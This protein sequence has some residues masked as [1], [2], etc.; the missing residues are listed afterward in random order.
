MVLQHYGFIKRKCYYK[1]YGA[2]KRKMQVQ[3]YGAIKRKCWL[4]SPENA[5]TKVEILFLISVNLDVKCLQ[6]YSWFVEIY[7]KSDYLT[8]NMIT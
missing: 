3:N 7:N 6:H 1:N 8:I 2:I 4:I 5:S